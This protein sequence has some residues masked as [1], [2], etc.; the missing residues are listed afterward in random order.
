MNP[1]LV[2]QIMQLFQW[3]ATGLLKFKENDG[4]DAAFVPILQGALTEN[5]PLNDTEWAPIVS[6]VDTASAAL[7]S[8]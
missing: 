7:Q 8:A 6:L 4:T 5:R 1:L 3:A 2:S